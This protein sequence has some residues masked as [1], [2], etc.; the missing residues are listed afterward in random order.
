MSKHPILD[1][2]PPADGEADVDRRISSLKR[3]E[4]H[5]DYEAD[6]YAEDGD[7]APTAAAGDGPGG[8]RPRM[9]RSRSFVGF[10]QGEKEMIRK[11]AS[12]SSKEDIDIN[13]P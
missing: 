9:D 12:H 10:K 3:S 1:D 13:P 6:D 7:D 8:G 5:F 11:G 4:F 2:T